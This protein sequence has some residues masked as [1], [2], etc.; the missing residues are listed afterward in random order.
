MRKKFKNGL[1]TLQRVLLALLVA[2]EL[3]LD[4]LGL[5]LEDVGE[6]V[7]RLD[8]ANNAIA[9]IIFDTPHLLLYVRGLLSKILLVLI[10]FLILRQVPFLLSW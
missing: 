6:L 4:S 7:A 9:Q 3:F 1:L 10:Q 5:V 2:F 8:H